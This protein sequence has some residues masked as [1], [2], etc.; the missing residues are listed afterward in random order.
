MQS[1]VGAMSAIANSAKFQNFVTLVILFAGVVVGTQTYPSMMEKYGGLLSTL[2]SIILGVFVVE[3]VIK[4][5]AEGGRPWRYFTDPWNVFD[6]LIV[7]LCFM[8]VNASFVTV[9]RLARILRVLK[10]VR[11][12]PKLQILVGALLRSIPS[13]GY[14]SLLLAMLF[15]LYAVSATFIFSANDPIHF[16]DLQISMLSLFRVVTLEDWTDIMYINMYGCDQY[17]YGGNEA[18]CTA[19]AAAPVF[20]ALFFVSFVLIGTMVIMNLF[21]GVIMTGMEEAQ[22]EAR[23]LSGAVEA[24][25][26]G[27]SGALAGSGDGGPGPSGSAESLATQLAVLGQQM[28]AMQ[29][30]LHNMERSL[31][32]AEGLTTGDSTL[33]RSS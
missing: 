30:Q 22:T 13:M 14:V 9:L 32:A 17:G 19:P 27:G 21:I 5:G 25:G 20:A 2:D 29:A 28:V 6:F 8:P 15:Y 12:L 3:I 24:G 33:P 7:V 1:L 23:Q 18:L 4:I 26:L 11:A 10:L 16:E 31:T